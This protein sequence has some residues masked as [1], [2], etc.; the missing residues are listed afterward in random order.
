M[1]K[2]S[3]PRPR[4][5]E[6][7]QTFAIVASRFNSRYVDGLVDH[8]RNE[9]R[10]LAPDASVSLHRVPGSFEIPVVV[11]EVASRESV[12]AIIACGV[13]MQGETN[14]AQNLSRSVTDALQRIAV[15]YGIPVI[16]V[17][18]SFDDE[19]Q[20]R[21]RCLENRINRGT[22]AARAAVEMAGVMSNLRGAQK[23][24]ASRPS[25]Q[26]RSSKRNIKQHP[27]I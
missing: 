18:L 3:P 27:R 5:A 26:R 1:S 13:I 14:H 19:D 6:S 8:A 4:L 12:D 10:A 7:A 22:E 16:N 21:A 20:A 9:L 17:V 11:R 2:E 23:A 24:A 15:E 25:K